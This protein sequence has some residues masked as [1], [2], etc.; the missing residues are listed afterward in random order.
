LFLLKTAALFHDAGFIH[1]YNKNEHLG[2]TMAKEILPNYGYTDK[3]L[4]IIEGLILATEIP[5]TPH[6]LLE[7]IMCDA[8][9]DYLGRDDFYEISDSL[10]NELIKFGKISGDRQWDQ[11]Q[12][13]FL[14][15]HQYFT[16]SSIEV[17]QPEKLKRIEEIKARLIENRYD[18]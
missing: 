3:Q 6:N 14:E 12:I 13:S 15:K 1:E 16:K 9:L 17:R 8:D 11:M 18:N 5:Q 10:K 4:K 7:M 2:V